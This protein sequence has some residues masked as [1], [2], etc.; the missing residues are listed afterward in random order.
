V[1]TNDIV[2]RYGG[3]EFVVIMP[4]TPEDRAREVAQRVVSGILATGHRLSN[5]EV[6]IGASAGLGVYP[7]DGRTAASLLQAADARMYEAK[8]GQV[9]PVRRVGEPALAPAI[10]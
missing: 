5:G 10:G 4:D 9:A 8:R 6:S 1:R 2:A 7:D 3:D